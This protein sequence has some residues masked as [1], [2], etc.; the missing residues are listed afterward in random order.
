MF[1]TTT[2]EEILTCMKVLEAIRMKK[3][4]IEKEEE[5][6]M[7]KLSSKIRNLPL[8]VNPSMPLS[9]SFFPGA[10]REANLDV[11]VQPVSK[12]RRFE[13]DEDNNNNNIPL[14]KPKIEKEE[15]NNEP[16]KKEKKS[17]YHYLTGDGKKDGVFSP[18]LRM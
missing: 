15:D 2:S 8:T 1:S 5:I 16:K 6:W 7:D 13:E 3:K 12:K 18:I 14:K 11:V 9:A 4:E 10:F 17:I